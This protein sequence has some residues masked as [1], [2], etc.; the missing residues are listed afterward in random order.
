MTIGESGERKSAVD[1]AA[2]WPH[3]NYQKKLKEAYE[4]ELQYY[5]NENDA[6]EKSRQDALR[7]A[8][9]LNE[10]KNDLISLGEPPKPPLLPIL[11]V[12]EPTYEGLIKLLAIGQPSE[13]LFSDEGGRFI[14]GHGMNQDNLLKT[15][16]GLSGLW[17]GKPVSRVRAGDG[18]TLIYGRRFSFHLMAQPSVS[19]MMLSNA[20]LLEQGL[21]S[22][23]LVSWPDSTAGTR[24]YKETDLS[25]SEDMKNY[26]NC[27]KRI[28]EA[29]LPLEEGK[30][31]ELE[32][33]Q[34]LLSPEA[35]Q[36]WIRFHDAIEEKLGESGQLSSIRGFANKAPEHAARLAGIVALV[37][38]L[39]C[40]LI[41]L[42]N[43]KAGIALA[44]YYLNEALRLFS[45]GTIDPDLV[46]AE[47]LLQWLKLRGN[48]T[49][50]LVEI[51]QYGPNGIRNAKVARNLMKILSEHGYVRPI[52]DGVE[53]EGKTRKESWEVRI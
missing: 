39:A 52:N 51:Y 10:K 35:K 37:E 12:E 23:C 43:M 30:Q 49:V 15:A 2:L 5:K 22:R 41:S 21:L 38:D 6:Y 1:N 47:K 8:K 44:T 7:K 53:F 32:P 25:D 18:S 29:P 3:R 50:T 20:L 26:W 4:K 36:L 27:L 48:H 33:C 14:G 34:L 11:I 42:K 19:Q 40:K 45:N 13:G 28:L 31:N 9:T 46:L 24:K 17:D 16:A